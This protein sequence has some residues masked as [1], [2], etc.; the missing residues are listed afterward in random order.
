MCIQ[1]IRTRLLM[2]YYRQIDQVLWEWDLM[3]RNAK[4][5]NGQGSDIYAMVENELEPIIRQLSG[6]V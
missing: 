4:T 5:F 3:C 1:L 6:I 2:S